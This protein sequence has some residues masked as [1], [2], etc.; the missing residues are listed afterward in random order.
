MNAN[1]TP[2]DGSADREGVG[3]E[4]VER[5]LST[6]YDPEVP[7]GKFV[8]RV[9]ERMLS[10]ARQGGGARRRK[11]RVIVLPLRRAPLWAAA[12][13]VLIGLGMLL[14]NALWERPEA[15]PR[16]A[17]PMRWPGVRPGGRR[18]PAAAV[19]GLGGGGLRAR[20][21]PPAAPASPVAVGA[22][23]ETKARRRRIALPDGSVVYVNERTRLK[24]EGLRR[25]R[26]SAGEVYVEVAPRAGEAGFVVH[27]PSR[28][29]SARGTRF[30]VRVGPGGTDVLVTQGQVNVSGYSGLVH[31]GRQLSCGS[32]SAGGKL[33]AMPRASHELEW[34]KDLAAASPLVPASDYAGGALVAID[35]AG[36]E[37]RLSL[38]K[39]HIDVHVEDGFAR[40]TIDQTYFNHMPRRLE[41]TFYF[42]LPPDA[43]ISRLGMYVNGKLMEGGMAERARARYVFETIMYTQRDPALLEWVD[44]STFKMRVFPLEG[45][46][47]KRIILSYTQRLES[48]YGQTTYR[49][50]GGHNMP[51]VGEWSFHA[52]VVGAAELKWALP[53]YEPTAAT[54]G[55]DLLIDVKRT[56]VTPD[57]DVVLQ[58]FDT[59]GEGDAGK[60]ERFSTAVNE[61]QRYLMLRFRPQLQ[62]AADS[63]RRRRDWVFL[64]ESSGDRDPLLARAQIDAV[65]AILS[66]APREDRFAVLAAGT[67]VRTWAG[68]FQPATHDN[69][70]AAARY[71]EKAHLVGALD[72]EGA[73]AAAGEL[74]AEAENPHLVHL[75][76]GIAVL[77]ERRTDKLVKLVPAGCRYV[78]VGVGK[79]YARNFMKAA[80][81]RTGGYFTQ[82]NPDENVAW[83]GFELLSTLNTPRL[84]D[85]KVSSEPGK[86]RWL[87]FADSAAEGEEVCAVTRLAA[88]APPLQALTVAGTLDGKDWSQQVPV[89]N[90]APGADY[91]PRFW[92]KLEIDR[93]LADDAKANKPGIIAL[94]K[95]MYV[96]SPFTSL[97]VLE[98]EAMYAQYKVDRGRKD[99]WALYP[100]P[101]QIKVVRERLPGRGGGPEATETGKK[102]GPAQVLNTIL[103]RIPP[104]FLR[105]PNQPSHY[106]GQV[107]TAWQLVT[108]AYAVPYEHGGWGGGG[109]W[110]NDALR[111]GAD[112]LRRGAQAFNAGLTDV[113]QIRHADTRLKL[114]RSVFLPFLT[115][116]GDVGSVAGPVVASGLAPAGTVDG[117]FILG[118]ALRTVSEPDSSLDGRRSE[119]R[120]RLRGG[121][122]A[123]R[124]SQR[125]PDDSG[126]SILDHS[127]SMLR[128]G[129]R[130]NETLGHFARRGAPALRPPSAPAATRVPFFNGPGLARPSAEQSGYRGADLYFEDIH[131]RPPE[132]R[133]ELSRELHALEVR[134]RLRGR[135]G[136]RNVTYQRP[137]FSGDQRVFSDLLTYAPGMNTTWA[138]IQAVV[139]A[140]AAI[141]PAPAGKLDPAAAAMIA[142]ARGF[143]WR[144]VTMP[145]AGG[146]PALTIVYDGAGRYAYQRRTAFG[147][148]ERVICDGTTLWHLYDEIGLGARRK[149]TRFHHAGFTAVV[150]WALPPAGE[151]ARHMNVS[152]VDDGTVAL[153]PVGA[154]QAKDEKGRPVRYAAVH[155][156]FAAD[157]RLAERRLVEMPKGKTLYR[158]TYD[159]DGT[160]KWLDV[161]GKVLATV[162]LTVGQAPQPDLK[163]DVTALVILPMPLRTRAHVL[164]ARKLKSGDYGAWSEEDA[165]ALVGGA[166]YTN[167]YEAFRVIGRRFLGRQDRRIGF[168]TLMMATNY[169]WDLK[170]EFNFGGGVKLRVDPARDLPDSPLARYLTEQIQARRTGNQDKLT[171]G[172]GPQGGFV[173]R[174]GDFRY[175]YYRWT[176]RR[177]TR[178]SQADRKAERERALAFGR[179]CGASPF[180]WALLMKVCDYGGDSKFYRGLAE[181]ARQF[182]H[183]SALA[184]SGRYE[185]ARLLGRAGEK[186]AAAE[187]FEKLYADAFA[188]GV[189]PPIDSSFRSALQQGPDGAARWARLIRRTADELIEKKAPAAVVILAWQVHACGDQPLSEELLGRA[190]SEAP[191]KGPAA[192]VLTAVEFLCQVGQHGRADAVLEPLLRDEKLAKSPAIWHLAALVAERRGRTASA[193]GRLERAMDIEFAELP[194]VI[195]LQAV[196][197]QYAGLLGKY[198]QLAQAVATLQADPP[199]ALLGRVVAAAD[200][201]R[202]LDA[203]DT[204]ACQAAARIL[205][206]LGARELAWEYL[207][208]PLA[209]RPNEAEPWTSLARQ[210]KSQG[211]LELADRAY[212]SAFQAERTNARILWDRA[213]LLQQLGRGEA[214]RALYRR[215]AEGKWPRQFNGV[216]SRAKRYV[217]RE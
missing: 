84:L 76:S 91:L 17:R 144:S 158:Q 11:P 102:P 183:V 120:K 16:Q 200:R 199:K 152:R 85:V 170:N 35:P 184:Y 48:L 51:L 186:Q 33:A 28:Q 80:A 60:F 40:T 13:A 72:L 140:E 26:L 50:G 4:N 1:Q 193:L 132:D 74:L 67:H 93:L 66:N 98:N 117:T 79:R 159:T 105:W 97:L 30:G 2:S 118:D 137:Y 190:L 126:L 143:G 207:T 32:G 44:G 145:P 176:S 197:R 135:Y 198:F 139:E 110:S 171:P 46:Q 196:R 77:G 121:W 214:A 174:L 138:D 41:G 27:T 52:R 18:L 55:D 179:R 209:L 54:D 6:A 204:A 23:I 107:L 92:A 203:D 71:L 94:S 21:R 175:L 185:R 59:D 154:E 192:V 169:S 49:F 103:M 148:T 83:R 153:T 162:K 73:L 34:T 119:N 136:R 111:V 124:L 168:Y 29:V 181:V 173:R 70:A 189:L 87:L 133:E 75:G 146:Q 164:S 211:E 36:Q 216:Q 101:A 156:V 39:Y 188:A 5:L 113:G 106:R 217:G 208:T 96:M 161:E 3:D 42:P 64:F 81:A 8:R 19:A 142:R 163:P 114:Q 194:E 202:A 88:G 128:K 155:L 10:A 172:D 191:E 69:V 38:R 58:V 115:S 205:Q 14:S 141:A 43:S 109:G 95:A 47:E 195:N 157:G 68:S 149:M 210:L 215:I 82:I 62:V 160:V 131:G 116:P 166:L 177:A 86:A 37:A 178:G 180:G 151:L 90:V 212:A 127:Y 165:L 56:H 201:W 123:G 65:E 130:M 134:E 12:A 213:Q 167:S 104:Q 24:V 147:L 129:R 53:T 182:E 15:G 9:G 22:A 61:N 63:G 78:G 112:A 100:A 99:H 206:V 187:Q 150:P 108:G 20:P 7:D 31:A 57:A 45:R 122:W 125:P 89:A 25:L